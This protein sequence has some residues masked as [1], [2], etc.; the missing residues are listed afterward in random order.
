MYSIVLNSLPNV[1]LYTWKLM[2]NYC[3]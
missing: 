3:L 2:F 1:F